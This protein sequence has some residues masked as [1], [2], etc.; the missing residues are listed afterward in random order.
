M[1]H[2]SF[3]FQSDGKISW[4]IKSENLWLWEIRSQL[5][6][7]WGCAGEDSPPF[8]T[9]GWDEFF[10]QSSPSSLKNCV[11]LSIN[12]YQQIGI[13]IWNTGL[14]M[15]VCDMP[16]KRW[17]STDNNGKVITPN[18]VRKQRYPTPT[19][20]CQRKTNNRECPTPKQ[21]PLDFRWGCQQGGDFRKWIRDHRGR[22]LIDDFRRSLFLRDGNR[23][24]PCH[25]LKSVG[26]GVV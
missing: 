17:Y 5:S 21:A 18:A 9:N 20:I 16:A 24:S 1:S 11:D 13:I 7:L 26:K 10:P 23:S 3:F 15:R 6:K 8:S 22:M 12:C 14:E 2:S 25:A 4:S 19:I